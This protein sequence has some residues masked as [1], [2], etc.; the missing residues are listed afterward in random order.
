MILTVEKEIRGGV[1]H[2]I[3]SYTKANENIRKIMIK[4]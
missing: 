2:A 4:I 1:C 3:H